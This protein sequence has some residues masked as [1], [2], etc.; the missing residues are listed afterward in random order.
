MSMEE[1][2]EDTNKDEPLTEDRKAGRSISSICRIA[3]P[4]WLM[5]RLAWIPILSFIITFNIFYKISFNRPSNLF[6]TSVN[7]QKVP[8]LDRK[9]ISGTNKQNWLHTQNNDL[10]GLTCQT[11]FQENQFPYG[12]KT[13]IPPNIGNQVM[14]GLVKKRP[15]FLEQRQGIFPGYL[16][17]QNWTWSICNS[18][19][20]GF[21]VRTI[22][23][24][25]VMR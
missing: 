12:S 13:Q 14:M 17:W 10:S 20:D 11:K 3:R 9:L 8:V 4:P 21:V 15:F 7:F 1:K 23:L 2:I 6:T 19:L 24:A 22:L 25:W 18:Y 16:G 5:G